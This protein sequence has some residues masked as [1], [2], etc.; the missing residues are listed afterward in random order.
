MAIILYILSVNLDAIGVGISYGVRKI[1]IPLVSGAII[2]LFSVVYSALALALGGAL[3]SVMPQ[4]VSQMLGSGILLILGVC[5]IMQ[6]LLPHTPPREES[7]SHS[8][9]IRALGLTISLV[10]D[11]VACDFDNSS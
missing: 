6:A 2:A 11:P 7:K 4:W 9:R 10:L 5:I 8:F 1:H 3:V